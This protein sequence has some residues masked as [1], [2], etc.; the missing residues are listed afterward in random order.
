[1]E[2]GRKWEMTEMDLSLVLF[3][4]RFCKLLCQRPEVAE[5]V[6]GMNSDVHGMP[7]FQRKR[8]M[9]RAI[10][11]WI[12]K[13]AQAGQRS[14]TSQI[15][16]LFSARF[17]PVMFPVPSRKRALRLHIPVP[18]FLPLVTREST[19]IH[20]GLT[21]WRTE[22]KTRFPSCSCDPLFLSSFFY[23]MPSKTESPG[24]FLKQKKYEKT[25]VWK[26]DAKFE[27]KWS[28]AKSC[29]YIS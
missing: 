8:R 14:T 12:D 6:K 13:R 2:R 22:I 26:E 4:R 23:I 11:W 5:T 25:C 24:C 27:G 15:I 7:W 18:A 16:Y 17:P 3:T 20:P 9:G 10:Q 28:I 29:G 21:S 1:M 19:S